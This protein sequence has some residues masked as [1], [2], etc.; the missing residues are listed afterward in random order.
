MSEKTSKASATAR[1]TCMRTHMTVVETGEKIPCPQCEAIQTALD[2]Q[3]RELLGDTG[4]KVAERLQFLAAQ[5]AA[6]R[7]RKRAAGVC[8]KMADEIHSYSRQREH[9]VAIACAEE[10]ERGE[11]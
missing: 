5:A 6:I 11:G 8:R 7:E 9:G 3:E 1:K 10:I 2:E 4:K